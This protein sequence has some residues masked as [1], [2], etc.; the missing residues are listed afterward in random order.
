MQIGAVTARP[1][2]KRLKM[3]LRQID[4]GLHLHTVERVPQADV[5]FLGIGDVHVVY[6]AVRNIGDDDGAL[7]D[8]LHM[9]NRITW[10]LRSGL[11][12]L[13]LPGMRP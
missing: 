9:L 4:T 6:H 8:A 3:H 7:M 13:V 10:R 11:S 5:A 2:R 12:W 1:I